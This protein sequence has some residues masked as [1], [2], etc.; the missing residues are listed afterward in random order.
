MSLFGFVK[1]RQF[2]RNTFRLGYGSKLTI[3]AGYLYPFYLE[4]CYP[5]DT[6]HIGNN[7]L[8][9]L[10]P[11]QAPI[12]QN[13]NVYTHYF[14]V[15]YRLIWDDWKRFITKGV[16]GNVSV[17]YP[18]MDVVPVEQ[19][20]TGTLADY[21]RFPD[22]LLNGS[23]A[24]DKVNDVDILPFRAYQLIW[25]EYYRDQNL[26]DAIAI[27]KSMS[28]A[29][30]YTGQE[31]YDDSDETDS[32]RISNLPSELFQLR[33]RS[34]KK[35]YFTAGLPFAQRGD[36]VELPLVGNGS[37][38][39]SSPGRVPVSVETAHFDGGIAVTETQQHDLQWYQNAFGGDNDGLSGKL[40]SVDA[41]SPGGRPVELTGGMKV[42]DLARFVGVDLSSVSAATINEL[43]RAFAAQEYLE[44]TARGG[45]RYIEWVKTIFNQ[46]SSDARLQRPQFLG[47]GSSPIVISDIL[48]T[49][50]TT[51]GDNGSAQANPAGHGVG[52]QRVKNIDFHCEEHGFIIGIMSLMPK[53][54]YFQGMPRQYMFRDALDF[55]NPYFAHLGEQEI[56]QGEIYYDYS[57]STQGD[58]NQK[59]F[60]YT[61]RYAEMKFRNDEVHGDFRTNLLFWHMA[62]KFDQ[63]P[64]LNADFLHN[65]ESV[66]RVFNVN[67]E[68]I[69]KFWVQCDNIV[70]AKRLMPKS[71]TPRLL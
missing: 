19:L 59:L 28:G 29:Y 9:R 50:Q 12:M 49:S 10:A 44:A 20:S 40:F 57:D 30:N 41:Q 36:E 17:I 21:L 63:P 23:K 53:A 33:K 1:S 58:S 2:K 6:F 8:F 39:A 22:P 26:E 54:A 25:N 35:D 51:T 69:D 48:Q 71:G 60:G 47:G 64:A 45:S 52:I 67:D 27:G 15:P 16:D 65:F 18:T 34:W 32:G 5:N 42:S 38:V 66:D 56:H 13:L 7:I 4:H 3:K 70:T 37:L 62:R 55:Y 46:R 43:R 68:N 61:P 11:M 24:G 31:I 14:F